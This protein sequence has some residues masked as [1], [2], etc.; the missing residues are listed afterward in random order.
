MRDFKVGGKAGKTMRINLALNVVYQAASWQY[1]TT[2]QHE[3]QGSSAAKP[4][5]AKNCRA[6]PRLCNS[7]SDWCIT[8]GGLHWVLARLTSAVYQ[9]P[10][11][12]LGCAPNAVLM[13]DDRNV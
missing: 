6:Q 13:Q 11:L 3:I 2:A 4:L 10:N 12:H 9:V 1:A 8:P 5:L 7:G